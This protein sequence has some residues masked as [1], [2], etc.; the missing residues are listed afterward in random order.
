VHS[1]PTA[2][3]TSRLNKY[4]GYART[5]TSREVGATSR[6]ALEHNKEEGDQIPQR[7]RTLTLYLDSKYRRQ[8]AIHHGEPR[9]MEDMPG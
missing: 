4:Y 6:E 8:R 5:T 1:A 3:K 9:K 2:T 7:N